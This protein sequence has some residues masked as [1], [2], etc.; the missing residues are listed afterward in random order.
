[1]E[2]EDT[3]KVTYQDDYE[4]HVCGEQMIAA[5]AIKLINMLTFSHCETIEE[6]INRGKDCHYH[7]KD[8]GSTGI[9][10]TDG[11]RYRF[12]ADYGFGDGGYHKRDMTAKEALEYYNN[13]CATNH[14]KIADILRKRIDGRTH[15]IEEDDGED[16]E[17]TRFNFENS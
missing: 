1:M 16:D 12:V 4:Y 7:I 11:E 5:E 13:Y 17:N 15:Y 3:Y 10:G 6:A 2:Y 14:T 9:A 8:D